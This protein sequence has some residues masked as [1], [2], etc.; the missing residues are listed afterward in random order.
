ML[1]DVGPLILCVFAVVAPLQSFC[2][3][4]DGC[5]SC[6]AMESQAGESRHS[7]GGAGALLPLDGHDRRDHWLAAS[8]AIVGFAFSVL[9]IRLS[10]DGLLHFDDLSHYLFAKWAWTYPGHLL[11][12]WGRPGFTT[13]YFLPA[14]FGWWACRV[15][16]AILSA[17]SAFLAFRVA[18]RLGL[19]HAW[20]VVPFVYV[21]PLFFQLSQT[22]L[23][24]TALAFYLVLAVFLAQR[25]RW[26]WSAAVISVGFITRHEAILFLP[27]WLWFAWRNRVPLWRLWPVAWA[28]VAVN[29]IAWGV[30][31][32]APVLRLFDATPST[33][34]GHGGWL[35]FFSRSLEAWGPGIT[36]MAIVGLLCPW[37]GCRTDSPDAGRSDKFALGHKQAFALLGACVVLYFAAQAVIRAMGLFDSGGYARFLVPISPLVAI[38]ALRGWHALW[39]TDIRRRTA[40]L[41]AGGGMVFLWI[42]MERQLILHAARLDFAAELPELHKGTLAIRITT[43]VIAILSLVSATTSRVPHL[44]RLTRPLLPATLAGML[45]LATYALC[46][47]LRVPPEAAP[48]AALEQWLDDNGYE[49]REIITANPWLDY[50]TGRIPPPARPTIRAQL[51]MAPVGTLFAW[52]AQF[53]ASA[54]HDL[55]QCDYED[56]PA[57]REIHRTPPLPGRERPFLI[58]FEKIETRPERNGSPN[59]VS[60]SQPG[61]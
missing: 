47:P 49:G 50:K 26:S 30:G 5:M 14:K 60:T 17:A 58:V 16:S 9:F 56:S 57:F 34:Y 44:S 32:R 45:M 27:I 42:A 61:G 13:L 18:R 24:E 40:I 28:V 38:F 33:Q 41:V 20:A 36:V 25:G 39:A 1:P 52:E 29:G 37:V 54:D 4:E 31:F 12:E 7:R 46:H 22:T 10:P 15:L 53:A 2:R 21:Q 11:D 8:L 23:T 51:E 35:S 48:I 59:A 19:R 55:P 6:D 3:G 43:V